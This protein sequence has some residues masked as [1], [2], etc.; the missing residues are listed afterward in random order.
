MPAT[1]ADVPNVGLTRYENRS[2]KRYSHRMFIMMPGDAEAWGLA[3]WGDS[4]SP[5]HAGETQAELQANVDTWQETAADLASEASSAI[6]SAVAGG[7]NSAAGDVD[8]LK[9]AWANVDL[10]NQ[11]SSGGAHNPTYEQAGLAK[12]TLLAKSAGGTLSMSAP[13]RVS[14]GGLFGI[15]G[16]ALNG[17]G[18]PAAD[19]WVKLYKNDVLF[20]SIKSNANGSYFFA[21]AQTSGATYMVK[22]SRSSQSVSDLTASAAVNMDVV[23]VAS[24]L[25]LEITPQTSRRGAR[26]TMRGELHAGAGDADVAGASIAISFR[27]PGSTTWSSWTTVTTGSDGKYSITKIDNTRGTWTYRARYLGSTNNLGSSAQHKH[28]VN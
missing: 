11:D 28:T 19:V 14:S 18:S 2:F 17:D 16:T 13:A 20:E 24:D 3:P 6:A 1:K 10:F 15:A 5:C 21:L 12:A 7:H 26:F 22:W 9:R 25:S 8:L 4:C 23:Q 27:R